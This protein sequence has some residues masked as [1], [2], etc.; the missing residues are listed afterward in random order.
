MV[1]TNQEIAQYLYKNK[2]Y[3]GNDYLDDI[4]SEY[5]KLYTTILKPTPLLSNKI[6]TLTKNKDN[7]V[8]IQIRC[9]D[10]YMDTNKGESHKIRLND[11][12]SNTLNKIKT[13]CDSLI[14]DY[15]VFLTTDNIHIINDLKLI[16]DESRII[17]DDTTIQHLDR[18]SID[19]DNSKL[20]SDNIIL[21]QKTKILFISKY[22]N[23][24]RI[25]ALSSNHD[26]IYDFTNCEIISK[27][28]LFS[29]K[30]ILDF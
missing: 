30:E 16:F 10:C 20:F 24:G 7:I 13:K 25:A 3:S 23:Y 5:N 1:H 6:N 28:T 21:S 4:L 14:D 26:N 12:I 15:Y 19:D 11:K 2:I 27:K 18:K 9:G 22:S 17:Y 8:G 29:K